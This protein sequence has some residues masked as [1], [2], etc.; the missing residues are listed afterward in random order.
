MDDEERLVAEARAGSLDAFNTLIT[1]HERVTFGL[2]YRLLGDAAAA[3]DITQESLVSAWSNL[4]SFRGGAFK[5]WLLRIVANRAY[6]ELRRRRRRP[7]DSLDAAPVEDTPQWTSQTLAEA[8]DEFALRQELSDHLARG[9][10]RL[11]E[12]QRLVVVLSDV[13]GHSYEEIATIAGINLGTVKSRLSRARSRL[14]DELRQ[15]GE[16]FDRYMRQHGEGPDAR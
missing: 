15:H 10:Q 1:R 4:S 7:A 12:D 3:D 2:A 6:D 16:L 13:Y 9:L 11:P 8:P 5:S 14:R